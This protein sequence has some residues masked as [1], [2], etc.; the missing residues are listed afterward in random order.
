M[1]LTCILKVNPQRIL[2]VCCG[3]GTF[4]AEVAAS[5]GHLIAVDKS[6]TAL[7]RCRSAV[8]SDM[9]GYACMDARQLGFADNTF[10]FVYERFSLH[11]M[12]NWERAL[13]EMIRVSSDW[14]L[15]LEPIDDPR[16]EQKRNTI[17]AQQLFLDVQHEAGFE[18]YTHIGS[19]SLIGAFKCRNLQYEVELQ[20][21]DRVIGF[22][23]YFFDFS[24]F[25]LATGRP[26]HWNKQLEALRERLGGGLLCEDDILLIRARKPR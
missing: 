7:L 22:D 15:A 21:N 16:N 4:T 10:D 17:A 20:R 5:G 3:C 8:S 24:R 13:D 26:D 19:D 6:H 14:I 23:D 2:D 11:H 25:S 9:A 1:I 12:A 18:H